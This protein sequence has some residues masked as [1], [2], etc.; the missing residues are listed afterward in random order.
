MFLYTGHKP[1]SFRSTSSSL[2][3]SEH[4]DSA[5]AKW[6]R[7]QQCHWLF[8]GETSTVEFQQKVPSSALSISFIAGEWNHNWL[9]KRAATNLMFHTEMMDVTELA[10]LVLKFSKPGDAIIFPWLPS[11]SLFPILA[12]HK[13]YIYTG[14][15]DRK[16]CQEVMYYSGL[17]VESFTG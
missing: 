2:I 9:L 11:S 17:T 6:Y 3:T 15:P 4:T 1:I 13:R 16:R 14:D 8:L 12:N 10:S 7:L 5:N